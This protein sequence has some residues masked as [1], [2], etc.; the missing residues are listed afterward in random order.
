MLSSAVDQFSFIFIPAL[1]SGRLFDLGYLRSIIVVSSINLVVCT[2]LIAECHQYW[3]FLL[4]QGFG[5]G[6][7]LL[8][9]L[10]HLQDL[11]PLP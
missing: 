1:I 10:F 4:C 5:I 3:Q 2:L 8:R 6:V 9:G 7:S 11:T